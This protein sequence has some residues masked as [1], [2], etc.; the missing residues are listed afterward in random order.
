MG[1]FVA[2]LFGV[3]CAFLSSSVAGEKGWS[4]ANWFF[5]GF[6]FGPFGL[7]AVV[8]MPDRRMRSYLRFLAL[9]QGWTDDKPGARVSDPSYPVSADEQRQRILGK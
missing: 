3:L 8:G 2:L 5:A 6:L 1:I 7:L 4:Q 9:Q